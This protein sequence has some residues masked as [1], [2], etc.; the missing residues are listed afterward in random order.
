VGDVLQLGSVGDAQRDNEALLPP[1]L[2]LSLSLVVEVEVEV[3]VEVVVVA[4]EVLGRLGR[5][6]A[7]IEP[8][9]LINGNSR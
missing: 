1:L 5:M 8:S 9:S 4:V 7:T 6:P 3:V 2:S